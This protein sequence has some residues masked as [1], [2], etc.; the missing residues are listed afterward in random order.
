M[1]LELDPG[2]GGRIGPYRLIE[3]IGH[4]GSSRVYL[5][6]RDDAHF[7]RQVAVK[8][9]DPGPMPDELWIARCRAERQILAALDHPSI[10]RLVD[11]GELPDGRLYFV[12]EVV[13][14][15]P[16]DRYA[17]AEA[18]DLEARIRLMIRVC[19][20]VA[21]AHEHLIVHR[22]LKPEHLL[23][24]TEGTPKLLDFGIAKVLSSSAFPRTLEETAPGH[25]PMTPAYAAPEQIRGES[26]TT[27]T[28]VYALGLL[29]YELLVGR[30]A[31]T[32]AGRSP[33]E[34]ERTICEHDPLPPSRA[35]DESARPSGVRARHL[36][37][38]LDAIVAMALAKDPQRRYRSARPLGDDLRRSLDGETVIARSPT[39]WYRV[40][41]HAR[42]HRLGVAAGTA[43]LVV[44]VSLAG[45][46]WR[47]SAALADER[48]A[49]RIERDT[50]EAVTDFLVET[51]AEADPARTRGRAVTAREILGRGVDKLD[52]LSRQPQV[53]IRLR[54]SLGEVHAG[55]GAADEAIELLEAAYERAVA[56]YGPRHLDVARVAHALGEAFLLDDDME[57]AG[58]SIAQ[59]LD[60]RRDLLGV[61]ARATAETL[62]LRGLWSG[63]LGRIE[64]AIEQIDRALTIL[65]PG[66]APGDASILDLRSY[67]AM[68][69]ALLG[70]VDEAEAA[71]SAT[72]DAAANALGDDHPITVEM[73]LNHV[74]ILFM[75]ET[76]QTLETILPILEQAER[77]LGADHPKLVQ[78]MG[79]ASLA[80]RDHDPQAALALARRALDA[81]LRISGEGTWAAS[82]SHAFV[83]L[84]LAR[85]GRLDEAERH[86]VLAVEGAERSVP[87]THRW[88]AQ[89]KMMLARYL[90]RTERY[91]DAE[92]QIRAATEAYRHVLHGLEGL[93]DVAAGLLGLIAFSDGRLDDAA[94]QFAAIDDRIPDL[95]SAETVVGRR[96]ASARDELARR[97]M[98]PEPEDDDS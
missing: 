14:G 40:G 13:D 42:R 24:T 33:A 2:V 27:A 43:V 68:A 41:K 17:D 70:R 76:P 84:A 44:L 96:I 59:A 79:Q 92:R 88:R 97:S 23:V 93:P 94:R 6:E 3:E 26:I 37:G 48:D 15:L 10:A 1:T 80:L 36:A 86:F 95:F 81:H 5:A 32:L 65:E 4:G 39:W 82:T 83:G 30:P 46:L 58:P 73:Q 63:Q 8:V 28:D 9:V 25:Q 91:A 78:S 62:A 18:L 11:G 38:D 61:D 21:F 77:V 52:A 16:I 87:V 67:R 85:L 49:A 74:E 47:Q 75:T 31:Y 34:V 89:S 64:Q 60:I 55:L 12:L 51:F 72:L 50:A 22:D 98:M 56:F 57:R 7:R 20:A 19:D 35:L 71:F 69:L 29:L 45:M 54:S 90:V 66:A 53:E